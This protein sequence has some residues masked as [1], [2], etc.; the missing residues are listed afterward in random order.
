MGIEL[1][2][3]LNLTGQMNKEI[4]GKKI[5]N[6][7]LKN[8]DSLLRMGFIK[9]RPKDLEARLVKKSINS[10]SG[11]GKWLF[12]HLKPEMQL[13]LGEI[14]GKILYHNSKDSIPPKYNLLLEFEDNTFLT[15]TINFYGFIMVVN[16][17]ELRQLRYPG[18]L[19]ISPLDKKFTF[20]KFNDILEESSKE[21]MGL[22]VFEW[23]I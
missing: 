2:E 17:D 3:V 1:L 20:S 22:R 5:K 9:P 11:G 14:L 18:I 19:G 15:V 10:I 23:V 13:V 16:D 7:L 8:Y 4:K 6:A 21:I 12:F